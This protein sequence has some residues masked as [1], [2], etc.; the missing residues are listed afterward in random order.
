MDFIRLALRSMASRWPVTLLNLIGVVMAVALLSNAGFFAHAVDRAVLQQ[1]LDVFSEQTGRNPFS[2]RVYLFPSSRSPLSLT[3]AE[4]VAHNL[5]DTLSSEI[6]LPLRHL[7]THI[8]SGSVMLLPGADD[9]R[10]ASDGGYLQSVEVVY[11]D[12]VAEQMEIV[13]GEPLAEQ[14]Q[15]PAVLDVWMHADL[16]ATMGTEPGETFQLGLNIRQPI[17]P[18]RI[19]GTWRARDPEDLFWFS[20]PDQALSSALIVSKADYQRVIEPV[21]PAKSRY[22]AWH[23]I[24]DDRALNP[25]R[26]V[27]Y[28]AGFAQA[29]AIIDRYLPDAQLDVSPLGPLQDFTGRQSLLATQ[30]LAFNLPALIFLLYFLFLVAQIVVRRQEREI[31]ILVSRGMTR[32]MLVKM[33]L[34]EQ[35]LLFVLAVPLGLATGLLLARLMGYTQSFLRF[36]PREPLIVSLQGLNPWLVL[37]ALGLALLARLA[38]VLQSASLSVVEQER[39]QARPV[40]RPLWQRMYLDLLLVFPTVYVYRQLLLQGT[41]VDPDQVGTDALFTD[42]LLVLAPALFIITTTL[43]LMR[44]FPLAM[45]FLD[46]V[47]AR[48]PWLTPHMV[49]RHLGRHSADYTPPLLLV[50]VLLALG[51]YTVTMAASLDQWLVNRVYYQTG[52]DAR[53]YPL[54]RTSDGAEAV[55]VPLDTFDDLPGVTASARVGDYPIYLK[56]AEGTVNGRFVGIDRLT[57]PQVAWFRPDLAPESLGAM[58]NRLAQSPDAIL[59][60]EQFLRESSLRIGDQLNMQVSLEPGVWATGPFTI[61]GIYTHF[62]TVN[63]EETVMIGNLDAL[64]LEVGTDFPHH[65]W[66]Q[67]QPGASGEAVRKR[68]VE[69]GYVANFW[70]S[71]TDILAVEQAQLERVGLFGTL[72]VGFGAAAIMAVLALVMYGAAS[73]DQRGFQFGV[74]RALGLGQ[75]RLLVQIGLEYAVLTLYGTAAGT[76]IG[77]AAAVLFTPFFR[78]TGQAPLPLPPLIPEIAWTEIFLLSLAFAAGMILIESLLVGRSL[79]RRIFDTLRMGDTG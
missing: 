37:A 22:A 7:G 60:S 27:S 12:Q 69:K 65:L 14:S 55:V 19:A 54:R 38:P 71:A 56:L 20:D 30:L 40:N 61:A 17:G 34:V 43:L 77:I 59:V 75:R 24:L 15:D 11:I 50:I 21:L 46:W 78:I 48:T 32:W 26:A 57:F 66:L 49:L 5:A 67:L 33:T 13:A 25:T 68:I 79:R 52:A 70:R 3:A 2:L 36:T 23:I 4:K 72:S 31:S 39:A 35:G 6:G 53:F 16:A 29:M 64:F 74:L 47:A 58:M 73:L 42:P 44:F 45:I 76:L 8:E 1:E 51:I 63:D 18:I 28:V 41:F 62:P 9:E 10:Y